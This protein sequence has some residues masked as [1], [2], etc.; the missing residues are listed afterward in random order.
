MVGQI[1]KRGQGRGSQQPDFA[2]E[3][4]SESRVRQADRGCSRGHSFLTTSRWLVATSAR[5]AGVVAAVRA[6]SE[7]PEAGPG[8]R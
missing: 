7:A 6:R 2:T 1:G 8:V 5:L 3:K 4:W